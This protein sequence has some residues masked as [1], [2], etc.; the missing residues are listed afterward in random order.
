MS[1]KKAIFI[2]N[3]F[4]KEL[5]AAAETG[6][7]N[8]V[9]RLLENKEIDVNYQPLQYFNAL[10]YAAKNNHVDIVK[11]LLECDKIDV[12]IHTAPNWGYSGGETARTLAIRY[13]HPDIILALIEHSK[14]NESDRV[15]SNKII[16]TLK[17]GHTKVSQALLLKIPELF[18]HINDQTILDE[19]NKHALQCAIRNDNSDLVLK[20]M[21]SSSKLNNDSEYGLMLIDSL[22]IGK[23]KIA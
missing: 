7:L 11:R 18:S 14:K 22:S 8:N 9:N 2:M 19:L 17:Y 15:Y 16:D 20:L 13:D 23:T 12:N 21:E 3:S 4:E 5:V 10:M 1:T 6:D